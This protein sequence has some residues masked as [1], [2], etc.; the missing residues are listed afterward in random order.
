MGKIFDRAILNVWRGPKVAGLDIFDTLLQE[1]TVHLTGWTEKYTMEVCVLL[2]LATQQWNMDTEPV[3]FLS[4]IV[5]WLPVTCTAS[6]YCLFQ[7]T[8]SGTRLYI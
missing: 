8:K 1:A 4:A 2:P 7:P 3:V 6:T 5:S